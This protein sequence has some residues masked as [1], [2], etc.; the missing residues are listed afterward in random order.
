MAAA[1][2]IGRVGGLA[3]A[4]GVG[5]AI[6]FGSGVATAEPTSSGSGSGSPGGSYDSHSSGQR[7]K[8]LKAKV[9]KNWET[10]T[11]SEAKAPAGKDSGATIRASIKQ[12]VTRNATKP[13]V[14]AAVAKLVSV[15][16]PAAAVTSATAPTITALPV[17]QVFTDLLKPFAGSSPNTPVEPPAAW[18]LLAAARREFGAGTTRLTAVQPAAG[19]TP[20]VISSPVVQL[21]DGIINGSIGTPFTGDLTYTVVRGPTGG[22]KVNLAQT[23]TFTY[24]PNR[25]DVAA[26]NSEKFSVLVA[27]QTAF[28]TALES[29]PLIG[30]SVPQMLV[31]LRQIPTI[32][33]LLTPIIGSSVGVLVTVDLAQLAPTGT[34]VAYTDMVTSFDGTQISVNFFPASGLQQ[35]PDKLAPTILY[36]P[37]MTQPAVVD[38]YAQ[39][40][41][42][43]GTMRSA[44]Y[45][46]VTWDP[47]GEYFS[48]GV[49]QLDNPAY[50]GKDVSAIISWTAGQP[51]CNWMTL[52]RLIPV[53]A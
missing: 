9:Q 48:G 35:L 39:G 37:G 21:S 18:A 32:N 11:G 27:Q 3:V 5:T 29:I 34:P 38:P 31:N 23:G 14:P 13:A 51:A 42:G 53:W 22:G 8:S 44:G 26:G 6:V 43:V 30:G 20:S 16:R 15:A 41:V 24:L 25:A 50:E 52:R 4:L 45:N 7:A 28:D 33:G 1:R 49:L 10:S 2:Y 19:V 40:F 47:R 17:T 12:Q 46:V 36:G